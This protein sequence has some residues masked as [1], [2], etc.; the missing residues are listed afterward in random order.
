MYR[1]IMYGEFL[2]AFL[3]SDC[4]KGG[5]NVVIKVIQER[6]SNTSALSFASSVNWWD[7]VCRRSDNAS[8][9]V[10]S[11]IISIARWS[12]K[13][14]HQIWLVLQYTK[15]N[16]NKSRWPKHFIRD[17]LKPWNFLWKMS[18]AFFLDLCFF[19]FMTRYLWCRGWAF[20]CFSSF[21]PIRLL[22]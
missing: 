21:I 12:W 19:S 14:V 4:M 8:Y 20:S 5:S 3:Y 7:V 13:H 17:H 2:G 15:I 9:S 6:S 22:T 1:A 18:S 11:S 10:S 16:Q